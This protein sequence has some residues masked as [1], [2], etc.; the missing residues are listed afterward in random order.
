MSR[1]A[2]QPIKIPAGVDVQIT[3]NR[4][5]V[6]GK[7]GELKESFPDVIKI[8]KNDGQLQLSTVGGEQGTVA[9]AGTIR[10]LVQNMVNGVSVGFI[11]KLVLVGVGYR[12]KVQGNALDLS[13]GFS[14]PYV[15]KMPK[16]ITVETP[17]NTEITLKGADKQLLSQVA[18]NIRDVR[19]PEPYK[20]KGIRY[21]NEKIVLKEGKKK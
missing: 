19:P 6:K 5:S 13:V 10:A 2:K 4:I 11:K 14:H 18:A 15:M 3:T 17:S 12:A 9:V 21:E 1:V 8:A 16:G 20:G 7:L